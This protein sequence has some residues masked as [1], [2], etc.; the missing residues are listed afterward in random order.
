MKTLVEVMRP[1]LGGKRLPMIVLDVKS[2][3]KA[4]KSFSALSA[5]IL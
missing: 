4:L 1:N 2:V 5:G 3:L